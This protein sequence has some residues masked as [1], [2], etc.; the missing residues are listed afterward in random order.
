MKNLA[1]IRYDR[2]S[3]RIKSTI[4]EVMW[5]KGRQKK[6]SGPTPKKKKKKF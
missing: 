2:F 4:E 1:L 3:S 6:L 5:I